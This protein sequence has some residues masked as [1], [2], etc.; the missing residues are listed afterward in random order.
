VKRV[1]LVR[2]AGPRNAGAVLRAVANFGPAELWFVAPDRPSLLVHPEFEQMAHGVEH[3]RERIRVVERLEE[4]LA[5]CQRS[6]GFTAR[7]RESRVRRDWLAARDEVRAADAAGQSV[8]LVFG[9]EETGLTV[10]EAAQVGELCY[11]AT[12]SEHTSI[13]LAMAAGIVLWSLFSGENVHGREDGARLINGNERAYLKEHLK[14]VL[15]DQVA[16]GAPAR[17]AIDGAIERVFTRAPIESRDARAWHMMMRALG[18]THTP[19]DFGL[20]DTEKRLR[21]KAAVK[22]AEERRSGAR[23]EPKPSTGTGTP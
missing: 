2:T 21:R 13:N 6:F 9:S 11:L 23:E 19:P 17:H 7:V 20:E 14:A 22:R 15:R 10:E 5:D 16:R 18:S 8:A 1:V 4:A 3:V 12:S